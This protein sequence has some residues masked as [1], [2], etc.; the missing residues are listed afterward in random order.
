MIKQVNVLLQIIHGQQEPFVFLLYI[1]KKS[2]HMLIFITSCNMTVE[3]EHIVMS[4][5]ILDFVEP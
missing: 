2:I 5:L 3:H 4:M 1:M